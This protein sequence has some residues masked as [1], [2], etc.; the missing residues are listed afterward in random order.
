MKYVWLAVAAAVGAAIYAM[1]VSG[2]LNPTGHAVL[3]ILAFSAVLWATQCVN[4]GVSSIVMMGLLILAGVRPPLVMSGFGTPPFWVLLTVLYYGFA[5]KKSGLAERISYYILS[6]FPCSYPG[7]LGAFFTIGLVLAL[8]IPSM[9]V[10][11]AIM[12]PIAWALV[13]SLGIPKK[14]RGSA[15]IILTT[16]EMA[17]IP[18]LAFLYGSLTGP[19]AVASFQA[20]H[21]PITWLG[22]AQATTVPTLL[23]CALILIINQMVLRPEAPLKANPMFAKDRLRELGRFSRNEMV[24]GIVVA[25][26]IIFWI[27]DRYHHQP[28]FLIGMF[29]MCAFAMS[30]ILTDPEINTGV[31]WPLLL[32]IGGIFGLAN[33]IQEYKI[34]DWLAGFFVP[35][36]SQLT[37]S[38]ALLG[39]V[40]S[41]A[42]FAMRFIDPSS[43]IAVSVLFL[44]VV[45]ITMKAG[46]DPLLLMAPFMIA[47]VPFWLTYQNF[48]LA[49]GDGLSGYEAFTPGQRVTI[50]NAYA[51]AVL[52]TMVAAAG[53]WK[54]IGL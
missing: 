31:S 40:M 44:S 5:M 3:A 34:T 18:G 42:M 22:Y 24:T 45:D 9:T 46:I 20:K 53:Y 33:V 51:I 26:S 17:V 8:G 52:I 27:T 13:Q 47:S 14:S 48:W 10:R 11:T 19:V 2:N 25:V 15:L 35:V 37:S 41:L 23:L 4:S 54:A 36:V 49:M 32:Y 43:F 50:A 1:P 21:L 30:G 12:T 39:V 38:I 7:I 16:V 28:S 6:L 29:A